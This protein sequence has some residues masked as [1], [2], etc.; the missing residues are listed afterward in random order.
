MEHETFKLNEGENELIKKLKFYYKRTW[1]VGEKELSVFSAEN[2]TNNGAEAYHK[3]LKLFVKVR[4]PNIWKF[5][6]DKDK[7]SEISIQ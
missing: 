3:T 7:I 6:S 4:N 2:A 1:I 5:L